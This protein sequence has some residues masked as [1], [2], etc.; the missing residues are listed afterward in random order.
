MKIYPDSP[1]KST[2]ASVISRKVSVK[3]PSSSK[4]KI[5]CSLW[6]EP[7]YKVSNLSSQIL[8]DPDKFLYPGLING[9]NNHIYGLWQSV[10]LA[11]RLNRTLVMPRFATH[12]ATGKVLSVPANQ[13]IDVDSL[14]SFV[15]C[16][17]I[18]EFR[19][20]CHGSVDVLFQ[21]METRLSDITRFENDAGMNVSRV[22]EN[23]LLHPGAINLQ[24]SQNGKKSNIPAFP[25]S[26][27]K[28]THGPSWLSSSE[29]SIRE[30][31]NSKVP[32]ALL[33]KAF[34][35]LSLE[36]KDN[37]AVPLHTKEYE[38]KEIKNNVLYSA[39]VHSVRRPKCVTEAAEAYIDANIGTDEFVTI[40]WRYDNNDWLR[41]F[42]R[43]AT[44]QACKFLKNISAEDV[45]Q[46]VINNLPLLRGNN[47]T[48]SVNTVSV[49]I[50][51]PP[52]LKE[53]K[54][55]ILS[56]LKTLDFHM[57]RVPL[58]LKVY[59]TEKGFENCWK[60]SNWVSPSEILSLVEMEIIRRSNYF[61][62]SILSTWSGN[63]R[64]LRWKRS[65][66]KIKKMFEASI[67]DLAKSEMT[68]RM[69]SN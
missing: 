14:C 55:K 57:E 59:L 53:F 64:P 50:A 69:N 18:E 33:A 2:I 68:K 22:E 17:S 1:K 67:L 3:S 45:A 66:G 35:P 60:N 32:C 27:Y 25:S 58:D 47:D 31:Y 61:F 5:R 44:C 40:H 34:H 26:S 21:A 36:V 29:K 49:Y 16:I 28:M 30:A 39:I 12:Y 8:L 41:V 23:D 20:A 51:T 6:E 11:I 56:H 24:L 37:I 9:P 19:K 7:T 10:Y 42:S 65:D 4:M 15:S 13:I 62:Y 46:A 43:F 38:I 48:Q 52:S 54:L 63:I